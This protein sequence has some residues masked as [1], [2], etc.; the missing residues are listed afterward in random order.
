MLHF[1]VLLNSYC[2]YL[3]H[4]VVCLLQLPGDYSNIGETSRYRIQWEKWLYGLCYCNQRLFT[5][6]ERD[7]SC[8]MFSLCMYQVTGQGITLLDTVTLEK[9]SLYPRVDGHSQQVYIPH[10]PYR[11]GVSVVNWEDNQLTTQPTLECVGVCYSV[12]VMSPHTLC[13]C[14]R[15]S[16][17][18]SVVSAT[19]DI[20]TTRLSKP[21]DVRD[22]KPDGTAVLGDSVLVLYGDNLVVYENGV[23]SPGTMVTWPAGSQSVSG[24]SS[25]GVSRFLV[26][27]RKRKAVF[28]LDVRGKVCDK[29]SINT[30][31]WQVRDCTLVDG[32]LWVGCLNGDI[33]VLSPP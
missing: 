32:K 9:Y 33:I 4:A 16:G 2:I 11:S 28:T 3:L 19:N 7:V 18:V 10:G 13:A 27:D 8:S 25:D 6:E 21:E 15:G 20:V 1:L 22:K 26:C 31:S 5:V 29:I 17:S 23:S 14:D 30:D 12:G 24:M